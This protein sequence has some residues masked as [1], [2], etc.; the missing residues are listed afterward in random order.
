MERKLLGLAVSTAGR[1]KGGVF[2]VLEMESG[3][4]LLADGNAR[5]LAKP[6]RKSLRHLQILPQTDFT[7]ALRG[8]G[9]PVIH[10]QLKRAPAIYRAAI[11]RG[12][13]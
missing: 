12:G 7:A 1:D 11:R 10:R 4:A 13:T 3:Y 5:K 9:G 8:I 2:F 6:K